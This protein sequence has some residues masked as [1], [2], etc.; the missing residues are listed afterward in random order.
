[1]NHCINCGQ[2]VDCGR[3]FRDNQDAR[4]CRVCMAAAT[5]A[6][7]RYTSPAMKRWRKKQEHEYNENQNALR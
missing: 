1:M 6:T 5:M 4:R 7:F 2:Q 3:T